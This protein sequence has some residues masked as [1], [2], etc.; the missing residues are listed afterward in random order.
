MN[1]VLMPWRA[2]DPD[3]ERNYTCV[4]DFWDDVGLPVFT[5]DSGHEF[6]TCGS[7]RNLAAERAG[8]WE[9]AVFADADVLPGSREQILDALATARATGAYTVAYSELRWLDAEATRAVCDGTPPEEVRPYRAM[10]GPWIQTFAVRRDLFDAAGRFDEGFVGYGAQ[11]VAFF[12]AAATLGGRR[13]VEGPLYH[14]HHERRP[15]AERL[16]GNW[17]REERY[18]QAYG[19]RDRMLAVIASR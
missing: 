7:S 9:E 14:L 10:A 2:G 3:R 12:K 17:I 4:R 1:V 5:A 15:D 11:D 8:A 13:R 16:P 18:N 6:F 19:D